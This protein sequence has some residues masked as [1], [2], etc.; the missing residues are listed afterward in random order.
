MIEAREW[1]GRSGRGPRRKATAKGNGKEAKHAAR[2][3]EDKKRARKE[4]EQKDE[5][6]D[7]TTCQTALRRRARVSCLLLGWRRGGVNKETRCRVICWW[8]S[9]QWKHSIRFPPH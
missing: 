8:L 4:K 1:E 2:K 9:G 5:D 3:M 7:D 6:K